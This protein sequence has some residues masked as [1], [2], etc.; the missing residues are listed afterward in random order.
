MSTAL[1]G[2]SDDR[3]N[4]YELDPGLQSL[5]ARSTVALVRA[6]K[7]GPLPGSSEARVD[8]VYRA[9]HRNYCP[10]AA[11]ECEEV[12]AYCSGTL[13]D[14]DTVIT[15]GHCFSAAELDG[16]VPCDGTAVVFNFRMDAEGRR[17]PILYDRDVYYCHEI[18]AARAPSCPSSG[19]SLSCSGPGDTSCGAGASCQPSLL[20]GSTNH[21]CRCDPAAGGEAWCRGDGDATATCE[22]ADGVG[23]CRSQCTEPMSNDFAVFRIKRERTDTVPSA[24]S[25]PHAPVPVVRAAGSRALAHDTPIWTIGHGSGLPVKVSPDAVIADPVVGVPNLPANARRLSSRWTSQDGF[26]ERHFYSHSDTLGGNSGGGTFVRRGGDYALAGILVAGWGSSCILDQLNPFTAPPHAHCRDASG[27]LVEDFVRPSP[28]AGSVHVLADFAIDTLCDGGT[29][30]SLCGTA[31]AVSPVPYVPRPAP[32][33]PERRGGASC[34]SGGDARGGAMLFVAIVLAMLVRRRRAMAL[35]LVSACSS[36]AAPSDAGVDARSQ[37]PPELAEVRF[38][39]R[40]V[41]TAV[42]PRAREGRHGVDLDGDGEVDN[43]LGALAD[44]LASV[45]LDLNAVLYDSVSSGRWVVLGRFEMDGEGGGA[46]RLF[47]G[48]A[49]E[50]PDPTG[51]GS[52]RVEGN[53][54]A[55]LRG[56]YDP[57]FEAELSADEANL[58]VPLPG[59]E[60]VLSLRDARARGAMTSLRATMQLGGLVSTEQVDDLVGAVLREFEDDPRLSALDADEDGEVTVLELRDHPAVGPLL[61]P[62]VDTDADGSP[63][64]FSVGVRVD[65]SRTAFDAPELA[66]RSARREKAGDAGTAAAMCAP[67][68]CA[69]ATDCGA[70]NARSECGWCAGELGCVARARESECTSDGHVWADRI[71]EC[72]DCTSRTTCDECVGRNAF[73]GWCPGTGCVADS[74]A[75]S[76]ACGG[77]Y[78]RVFDGCE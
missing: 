9:E 50:P 8:S 18:L 78:R 77:D 22:L 39:H 20:A 43:A 37:M 30:H 11:Y 52:H 25:E 46:L 69:D 7:V 60:S 27:C 6:A 67:D 53:A 19:R 31:P 24:V 5:V 12:F 36:E 70:C 3:L 44:A 45:G 55:V 23:S 66:T 42:L 2:P 56:S 54:V 61:R 41:A 48:V 28:S 64:H 4:Y 35:L 29:A 49:G 13:I 51:L 15:A 10:G 40:Y 57:S 14:G 59:G 71:T 73:C 76:L 47:R 16:S 26:P 1:V 34:S 62:D 38:A 58:W 68:P 75:A 72:E 21:F 63:D 74:S 65:W 33:T 17:S 32:T